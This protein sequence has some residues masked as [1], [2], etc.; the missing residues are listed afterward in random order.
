MYLVTVSCSGL[1][2]VRL[3]LSTVFISTPCIFLPGVNFCRPNNHFLA[4]VNE[5]ME[6]IWAVLKHFIESFGK[7]W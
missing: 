7:Q 6:S 1:S 4:V 3:E 2:I 5:L